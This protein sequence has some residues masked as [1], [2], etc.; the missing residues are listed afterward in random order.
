MRILQNRKNKI[1]AVVIIASLTIVGVIGINI[2]SQKESGIKIKINVDTRISSFLSIENYELYVQVKANDPYNANISVEVF[3]GF[4]NNSQL[5]L[6]PSKNKVFQKVLD[7]WI[8]RLGDEKFF[9]DFKTY[10]LVSIWLISKTSDYRVVPDRGVN[11]NPFKVKKTLLSASIVVEVGELEKINKT[12]GEILKNEKLGLK[13]IGSYYTT[14]SWEINENYTVRYGDFVKTPIMLLD[15]PESYSAQVTGVI[16][17]TMEHTTSFHVTIGYG[18]NILENSSAILDVYGISPSISDKLEYQNNIGVGPLSETKAWIY[19][20]AKPALF[21]EEEYQYL[22]YM[23]NGGEPHL[24]SK[25]KTGEQRIRIEITDIDYYIQDGVKKIHGGALLGFPSTD[26]VDRFF[27]GTTIEQPPI[28]VNILEPTT[29]DEALIY[30][31]EIING[32]DSS[33]KVLGIGIPIGALIAASVSNLG[34]L[35]SVISGLAISASYEKGSSIRI[36]GHVKNKAATIIGDYNVAEIINVAVSNY[37]YKFGSDTLS[38]PSVY[39]EFITENRTG[40]GLNLFVFNGSSYVEEEFLDTHNMYGLDVVTNRTLHVSPA[41]V[42][43][44]Y[45]FRLVEH[46]STYS[47]IDAVKLFGILD[48]GSLVEFPLVYANH[49]VYGDVLERLLYSDDWRVVT[50]GSSFRNGEGSHYIDLRFA[51]LGDSLNL[52]GFVFQI[53]GHNYITK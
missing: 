26:F 7:D 40:G 5:Y 8:Q 13:D 9:K 29:G 23:D 19:I 37:E 49:S 20:Y 52:V 51:S 18:S 34:M 6:N 42:N 50:L 11:Y 35:A 38:L 27:Y 32:Y 28:E 10:L 31:T 45:V 21:F 25:S 43:G 16:S 15:N 36:G 41:L 17:F 12:A 47:Y 14:Y 44:D 24:I 3:K 53:E 2:L 46:N 48:S 4:V 22:W 39:F 1:F 30:L 33:N